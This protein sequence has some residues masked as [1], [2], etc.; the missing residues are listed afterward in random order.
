MLAAIAT[1][2]FLAT[3]WMIEVIAMSMLGESGAKIVAALKGQ[4]LLATAPVQAAPV[5]V[6]I[7]QR[8]RLRRPV[9]AQ[10][11]LRAAA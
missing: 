1:A 7:S 10:P 8:S 3:L 11:Q 2:A 4:S 9:H 5:S 6:R